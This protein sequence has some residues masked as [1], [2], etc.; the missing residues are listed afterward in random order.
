MAVIGDL[1]AVLVLALARHRHERMLGGDHRLHGAVRAALGEH[2]VEMAVH[3]ERIGGHLLRGAGVP[4]AHH[5]GDVELV[6]GALPCTLA[7]A[8]MAVTVDRIAGQAAHLEDIAGLL[9]DF[10][11][12]PFAPTCGPSPSGPR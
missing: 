8:E 4:I 6:A 10:I 2:A 7:E 5:L 11:D 3:G 12:Q 1:L 9:A